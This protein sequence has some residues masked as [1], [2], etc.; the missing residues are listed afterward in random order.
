MSM[1][2]SQPAP[3]NHA[4]AAPRRHPFFEGVDLVVTQLGQTLRREGHHVEITKRQ[5]IGRKIVRPQFEDRGRRLTFR[6]YPRQEGFE[7]D[8]LK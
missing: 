3:G 8:L 4:Q 6:I 1:L 7:S 2:G 5:R